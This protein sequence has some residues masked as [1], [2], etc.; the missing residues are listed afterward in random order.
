MRALAATGQ[1]DPRID[2]TA[3]LVD[4][5]RLVK[6]A[7]EEGRNVIELAHRRDMFG[8]D[9]DPVTRGFLGLMYRDEALS[10]PVGRSRLG[11]ALS[12][13]LGEA[14]KTQ[15]GPGAGRPAGGP[16]RGVGANG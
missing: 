14:E 9:L 13:Y 12:W 15:P 16:R 1:I 8:G 3:A 11:E 6:R 10:R 7:R 4:A 5:V 2:V